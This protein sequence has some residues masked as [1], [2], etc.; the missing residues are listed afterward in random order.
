MSLLK[1]ANCLALISLLDG[2]PTAQ[3]LSRQQGESSLLDRL[4]TLN[5][6]P[7]CCYVMEIFMRRVALAATEDDVKVELAKILHK[8][9]F[10]LEPLLNFEVTLFKKYDSRGKVGI[11]TLPN[12]NAGRIFMSAYGMADVRVKGPTILFSLSNKPL[13]EERVAILNSRPWRDPQQL[14]MEK[15]QRI[16]E[17]KPYS[18]KSYAFGRFADR[19]FSSEFVAK[20]SADIACDLERRLVRFT[21]R[22]Q[23]QRSHPESDDHLVTLM[24]NLAIQPSTSTSIVSYPVNAIHSIVES[25]AAEE[26]VIF[27]R[28][29]TI[30]FFTTETRSAGNDHIDTRRSRGLVPGVPMSPGCFSLACTFADEGDKE[31]FIYAARSSFHLRYFPR[32]AI[33]SQK[34]QNYEIPKDSNLFQYHD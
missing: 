22:K 19:L 5:Y 25:G 27:I 12:E 16:R 34:L 18:L 14:K 3:D 13:N 2:T 21:L 31:A 1:V 33:T 29:N 24:L 11:L 4:R 23:G 17:G 6:A 28:A 8:A 20:G 15:E 32:Q 9:P 26:P 7:R 30:P 10:P